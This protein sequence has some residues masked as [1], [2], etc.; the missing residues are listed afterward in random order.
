MLGTLK[1][2]EEARRYASL[3]SDVAAKTHATFY[4][5]D[6]HRYANGTQCAQGMALYFGLAPASERAAVLNDLV[7]QI[8]TAGHLDVGFL[9]AK[10]VTRSLA[11][12]GHVDLAFRVCMQP[13]MPSYGYWVKTMGSTT[14]WEGW[15]AGPSYNHI[16]FGDISAW[17]HQW[18]AGVQQEEGS[19]GWER[20]VF[21]PNLVGEVANAQARCM[22]PRGVAGCS[23]QRAGNQVYVD[24][25]IPGGA[26]ARL[27]LPGGASVVSGGQATYAGGRHGVS[28]QVP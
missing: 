6:T 24:L 12:G 8:H 28:F 16:M 26:T 21:R 4:H 3:A 23:W 25:L 20:I 2:D 10:F 19:A 7:S 14:L 13:S 9:G 22:T 15:K 18:V 1:R 11:A 5:S 17:M 27:V